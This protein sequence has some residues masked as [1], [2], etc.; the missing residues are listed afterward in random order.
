MEVGRNS[1]W[2][3]KSN[4][5]IIGPYIE[6]QIHDLLRDRVIVP[7]DEV[8]RPCGRWVFFRD[9]PLFAKIIEEIRT[10]NLRNDDTT[11][12]GQTNT[13]LTPTDQNA[14]IADDRT[15]EINVRPQMIQDVIY[16]SIDDPIRPSRGNLTQAYAHRRDVS[17][18]HQAKESSRWVWALTIVIITVA[19]SF[20]VFQKYVAKPIIKQAVNEESSRKAIE[21]LEVGDFRSSLTLFEQAY[22]ADP[23]DIS[24][25]LYLSI[26]RIHF[27]DQVQ[28]ARQLL[29]DL[30][31]KSDRDRKKVNTAIGLAYLHEKDFLA[32][33]NAFTL[34]LNEDSTFTP[35][36]I[37]IGAVANLKEDWA[38]AKNYLQLAI[39]EGSTDGRAFLLLTEA[40]AQMFAV[41]K[42]DAALKSLLRTLEQARGQR[43]DYLQEL[44][45]AQAYVFSL[46]GQKDKIY[47]LIDTILDM[48][49]YLTDLHR[50][51]LFVYRPKVWTMISQWCLSLTKDLDPKP[52]I[53]AFEAYC[54]HRSGDFIDSNRKME[55]A[56]AQAPKDPL[57]LTLYAYITSE[58]GSAERSIA[59]LERALSLFENAQFKLPFRLKAK[60]CHDKGDIECEADY[61]RKLQDLQPAA[62]DAAAGLSSIAIQ[63]RRLVEAKAIYAKALLIS[64]EYIPLRKLKRAIASAEDREKLRGL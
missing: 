38:K 12:R 5:R 46:L 16:Q 40:V 14:V 48:D 4:G 41:E 9:E 7:L 13:N 42:S 50:H 24:V 32:A 33:E 20:V 28:S 17:L 11:T 45:I 18:N 15:Q 31:Q 59:S 53:I 60:L 23:T 43:L 49:P 8:S 62:I 54:L 57:I 61:W 19:L 63:S 55:D 64:S 39:Q 34:A 26:L 30:L 36:M 44:S 21:A 35:A 29:S 6:K 56:L 22:S 2:L 1:T 51:E 25:H 3:V 10:R 52:K 47:S 37:N 58:T 27:E